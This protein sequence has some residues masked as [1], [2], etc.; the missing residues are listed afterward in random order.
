MVLGLDGGM[1]ELGLFVLSMVFAGVIAGFVAGLLG[2]GGGIVLVPVLFYVLSAIGVAEE[3]RMHIAVGT[4][5][6]TIVI[7]AFFSAKT[8]YLKGS[9]DMPLLKSWGPWLF[10]GAISAMYAFGSIDTTVLTGIF[11]FVTLLVAIYMFLKKDNNREQFGSFPGGV[12]R[13]VSGLVVGATSSVMGIGGGTLS[14]PLLSFFKY[15]IRRAVGTAAAIGL[16]IS[17][18]GAIGAFLSGLGRPDLP[19]F[20]LGFVNVIAFIILVPITGMVAPFGARAAHV[21]KPMYLRY[22]FVA[23]L[24]FNAYNMLKTAFG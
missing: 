20:S 8:H 15:P 10:I 3:Y 23:F 9:I 11:G 1:L 5:L 22:S 19:P 17:I 12:F 18:P 14:V 16:I 13:S 4:S 6:T 21:I 7:T 24:L 2:V